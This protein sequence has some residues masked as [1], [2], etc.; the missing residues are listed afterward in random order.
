M[1][2][3]GTFSHLHTEL[4]TV[5]KTLANMNESLTEFLGDLAVI[6][7]RIAALSK[8]SSE[9][10]RTLTNVKVRP[11]ALPPVIISVGR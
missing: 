7:E 3:T 2:E 4:K 5:D 8:E 6:S 1:D 10:N 11:I 9:I